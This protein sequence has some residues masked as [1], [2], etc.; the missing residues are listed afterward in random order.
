MFDYINRKRD[1]VELAF[2]W[3]SVPF[4]LFWVVWASPAAAFALQA[5]VVTMC[6]FA[7]GPFNTHKKV[8]KQRWYWKRLLG[9]GALAHPIVLGGLWYLNM[10]YP[11]GTGTGTVFLIAFVV[12]IVE[13]IT[14]GAIVGWLS[15]PDWRDKRRRR[16]IE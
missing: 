16:L 14:V 6:T 7:L 4:A 13:M 9:I 10:R 2:Y 3:G 5:Y 12:G 15:V 8:V 11:L 1:P